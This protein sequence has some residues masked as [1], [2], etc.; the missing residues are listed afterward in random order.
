M[1]FIHQLTEVGTK[2]DLLE[3]RQLVMLNENAK[4]F[5]G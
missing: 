3:K 5:S 1:Q 2:Y 4:I